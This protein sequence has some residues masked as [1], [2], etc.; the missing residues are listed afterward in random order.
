MLR[1][2]LRYMVSG[3]L[4]LA[5]LVGCQTV[6]NGFGPDLAQP[7]DGV[8]RLASYNVHYIST[9]SQQGRW[10]LAGWEERKGP[11]DTAFKKL[12]ADI[13][14]F[15]EMESFSGGNADNDNLARNWLLTRNPGYAAAAIGDWREFPSTQ[16]IFYRTRRI[17]L[18]DQGWFFFSDTPDVIYSRTFN[19]SYPAFASWAQFRDRDTGTSFRVLN[20]H[21]DYASRENRRR[22]ITLAAERAAPWIKA[23]EVVFLA[24]DLNAR[25]RSALHGLLED[26]GLA[27]VPVKGATYHFDLG[28]NLFAAIDHIGY[29]GAEPVGE[30]TVWREKPDGVW[31]SD[32]YPLVADFRLAP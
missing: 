27:F 8:L 31:P 7:D 20:L 24:G 9:G 6:R 17:E 30:P 14:A 25:L 16:P 18:L 3:L 19:G 22:S 21:T 26:V 15:Q 4:L 32:H 10:G 23:G 2:L 29:A 1:H 28:L 5:L 13:V 12:A 11:L